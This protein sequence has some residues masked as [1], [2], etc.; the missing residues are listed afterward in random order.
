[1]VIDI[2]NKSLSGKIIKKVGYRDLKKRFLHLV[3]EF[4]EKVDFFTEKCLLN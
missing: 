1:M 4:Y 3:Y 2:L